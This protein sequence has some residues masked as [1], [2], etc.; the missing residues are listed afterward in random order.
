MS[1]VHDVTS[2]PVQPK[3]W[4]SPGDS[5]SEDVA[6]YWRERLSISPLQA[7]LWVWTGFFMMYLSYTPLFYSDLWGHVAYGEWILTQRRL[8]QE[9]PF[10]PLAGGVPVINTAWLSQVLL[11]SVVRV[12]GDEAL[13]HLFTLTTLAVYSTL[14]LVY[15]RQTRQ[16]GIAFMAVVGVFIVVWS[17]HAVIRP[18]GFAN[19]TFAALLALLTTI[20]PR[21]TRDQS[22]FADLC[23]LPRYLWFALPVT[24]LLFALWANLHGSYI[25]GL[26]VLGCYAL[27]RM[28]ELLWQGASPVRIVTDPPLLSWLGLCEAAV[29][30]SLIHP[31]GMDLLVSTLVFP[32]HP[33]LREVLEWYPLSMVSLEAFPMAFSWIVTVVL[34]RHSR[35]RIAA[36]DV[37]LLLLFNLAVCLRVRMIAW[38]GP[39]WMLVMAP[40]LAD[41]VDRVRHWSGWAVWRE[42]TQH[43]QVRSFHTSLV[44]AFVVW[45]CFAFSPISK[46]L[47]GGKPRPERHL[48]HRD[49][50]RLIT[51]YL[52]EHPPQGMVA[53]PQWWGD[54]LVLKG[55]KN[56]Q[57]MVTTN[58]VHLVPRSVW[59]D[60]LAISAGVSGIERRLHHYRINTLVVDRHKQPDLFRVIQQ[61]TD[62][63]VVYEDST[64]LIAERKRRGIN[65]SEDTSPAGDSSLTFVPRSPED[66]VL[67]EHAHLYQEISSILWSPDCRG[68]EE[69]RS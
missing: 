23:P 21:V 58:T 10:V 9:D 46:T 68:R 50:P 20:D 29:V 54:W 45:V 11:A 59:K 26:A 52:R 13:S 5:E 64:G 47:L 27:G 55:P 24:V 34:F 66:I 37:L 65:D 67:P 1:V 6:R 15:Y 44:T 48:Y 49:T 60:Y 22:T 40:H 2:S 31:L 53:A 7:L 28:G 63:E 38:Y 41:V 32:T 56:I 8:P 14:F 4:E 36:S 17:R 25:V 16:A 43:L 3:R 69:T 30:G 19:L 18:E 42:G 33:N 12:G 61:M 57:V 51:E 62:W 39:V 35:R